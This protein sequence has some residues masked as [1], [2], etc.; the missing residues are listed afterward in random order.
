MDILAA[1]VPSVEELKPDLVATRHRSGSRLVALYDA[2]SSDILFGKTRSEQTRQRSN[3][4]RPSRP[5]P[6]QHFRALLSRP[7]H[8]THVNDGK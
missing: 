3:G 5:H 2:V 4:S 1:H 8:S 7:G 6:L